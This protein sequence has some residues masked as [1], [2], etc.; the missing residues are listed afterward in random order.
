ATEAPPP[1]APA[2]PETAHGRPAPR[3]RWI[4]GKMDERYKLLQNKQVRNIEGFN[5]AVESSERLPYWLVVIDELADL[6]LVSSGDVQTALVRL[7]QI[8]PAGGVHLFIAAQRAS[9]DVG[10]RLIKAKFPTRLPVHATSQ[11]EPRAT[12]T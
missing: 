7:A 1:A 2:A 3:L 6:M 11:A 4:V 10:N 8:A 12:T 5:K 9:V